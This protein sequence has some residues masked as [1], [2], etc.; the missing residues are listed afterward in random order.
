M[1]GRD[2]QAF[3]CVRLTWASSSPQ[4]KRL[5]LTNTLGTLTKWVTLTSA[6]KIP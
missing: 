3:M 2:R 1:D 4:L 5:A 6:L